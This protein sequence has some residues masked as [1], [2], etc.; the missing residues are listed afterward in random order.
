[1][2]LCTVEYYLQPSNSGE[3]VDAK[4]LNR[5]VNFLWSALNDLGAAKETCLEATV[6][7]PSS[8]YHAANYAHFI[9]NTR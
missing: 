4:A 6:A 7:D 2:L 9:W 3:A 8:F 1:M 5:Y